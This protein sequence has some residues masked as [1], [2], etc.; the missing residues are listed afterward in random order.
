MIYDIARCINMK[1]TVGNGLKLYAI[2]ENL[3][4]GAGVSALSR[5]NPAL[6]VVSLQLWATLVF[7]FYHGIGTVNTGEQDSPLPQQ[8]RPLSYYVNNYYTQCGRRQA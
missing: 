7:S 8:F 3:H 4:S 6:V 1:Y 5:F 2:L